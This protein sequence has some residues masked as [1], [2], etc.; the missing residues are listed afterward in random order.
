MKRPFGISLFYGYN[1]HNR[2]AKFFT[3]VL[4]LFLLSFMAFGQQ[5]QKQNWA[6]KPVV[7]VESLT[8][9]CTVFDTFTETG[10]NVYRRDKADSKGQDYYFIVAKTKS[11]N[12]T[13]KRI[14]PITNQ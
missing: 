6:T 3:P 2:I 7:T 5:G 10:D 13:R 9:N 11:G 8:K 1:R 14:Y 12:L 4:F